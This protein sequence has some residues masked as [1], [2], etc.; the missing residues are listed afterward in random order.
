MRT[1]TNPD[2]TVTVIYPDAI[3]FAEGNN[4]IRITATS[5]AVLEISATIAYSGVEISRFNTNK[6]DIVFPI[7]ELLKDAVLANNLNNEAIIEVRYFVTTSSGTSVG[8]SFSFYCAVLNGASERAIT[9]IGVK[10]F[11]FPQYKKIAI[12]PNLPQTIRIYGNTVSASDTLNLRAGS[13]DYNF[14]DFDGDSILSVNLTTD[15]RKALSSNP[16]SSYFYTTKGM[17]IPVVVDVCRTGLPKNF[18]LQ[19]LDRHGIFCAYLFKFEN[20]SIRTEAVETF[21]FT[22]DNLVPYKVQQKTQTTTYRLNTGLIDA[23]LY[24]LA[25]SIVSGRYIELLWNVDTSEWVKVLAVEATIDYSDAPLKNLSAE[26]V[27]ENKM[28]TI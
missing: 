20:T 4:F 21:V 8:Q 14:L 11:G 7:D 18:F 9:D 1:Y 13:Q 16:D 10:I 24:E 28:P 25:A 5:T 3:V 2:G 19:W 6:R 17:T 23:D 15:M 27:I 22:D 26:I 12:Y